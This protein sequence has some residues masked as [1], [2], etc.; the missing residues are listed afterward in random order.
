M[1]LCMY[2]ICIITVILHIFYYIKK[3]K[4]NSMQLKKMEMFFFSYVHA[5]SH[6]SIYLFYI[7]SKVHVITC[8]NY[9]FKYFYHY[10]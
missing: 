9:L 10:Y 7:L 6:I 8:L 3:G 5:I 2:L 1:Y 4:N